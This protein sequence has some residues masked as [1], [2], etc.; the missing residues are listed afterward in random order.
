[1]HLEQYDASLCKSDYALGCLGGSDHKGD[2]YSKCSF[3]DRQIEMD[4]GEEMGTGGKA[5]IKYKHNIEGR[6]NR[7]AVIKYTSPAIIE[8]K[9]SL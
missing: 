6:G 4:L 7:Y 8:T 9:H 3:I 5:Q 2:V 1:M